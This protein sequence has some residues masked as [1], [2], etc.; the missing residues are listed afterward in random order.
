[1]HWCWCWC[2]ARVHVNLH[3]NMVVGMR[4]TWGGWMEK[5]KVLIINYAQVAAQDFKRLSVTT[6]L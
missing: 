2:S 3:A 6:P 5:K 4:W 1:M